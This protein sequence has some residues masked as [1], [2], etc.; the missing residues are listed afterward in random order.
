MST[1]LIHDAPK[2]KLLGAYYTPKPIVDFL[3]SW[4]IRSARDRV[5]EPSCGDACFLSAAAERLTEFGARSK[6]EQLV[7]CEIDGQAVRIARASLPDASILESDFFELAPPAR[8]FDVVIGNPPYVRYH[9]FR[10][11]SRAQGLARASEAGVDLNALTSS[12]APFVVHSVS[13]LGP[14]GR[15]AL[16]LPSELLTTDYAL[17]V[18]NYLQDRFRRIDVLTF[19][20][21]V[22]QGA[23]VDAVLVLAEGEGPGEVRIHRLHDASSLSSF[24]PS[25]IG[26][27]LE[28]KWTPQL[29]SPDALQSFSRASADM[30][31]LGEVAAV[32]IGLVT[33]ANDFFVLCESQVK[34]L[35]IERNSLRK[36]VA[37]SRQLRGHVYTDAD[38]EANRE[39]DMPAWLY[40]PTD[41]DV[42]GGEYV[43]SG[44]TRGVNQAY[45]CRIRTPWWRLRV[46]SPPDLFLGYMNNRF[47][48]LT[49]NAAGAI[50]T[51]LIHNVRI[52]EGHRYRIDAELLALA[53]NNSGTMLSCELAG[54]AYGGGVLKLETKEAEQVRI[55]RLDESEARA[56][57]EL[58]EKV[59]D[60]LCKG[61]VDHAAEL[62]DP[63]VL[64]GLTS[65]QRELVHQGWV[66]LRERR[67]QRGTSIPLR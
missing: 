23:Q 7:G 39:A 31:A 40:A 34:A 41:L 42:A 53:W 9:Y 5:L 66:D 12:W 52:R 65:Q 21:R 14:A 54:R 48:R 51:N 13:H 15:L 59:T 58:R 8:K 36:L 3:V 27:K 67:R 11:Q 24:L 44:E 25:G 64:S 32:D 19:E 16:V 35:R 45:K 43:R 49:A 2:Q 33:G 10:G 47:V 29:L 56:L 61:D 50:S 17:P 28:G 4:A 20:R 26:V 55:P 62:V 46:S 18:R 30:I 57:H 1:A 60:A 38:W 22:F 63:I 6:R 37:R